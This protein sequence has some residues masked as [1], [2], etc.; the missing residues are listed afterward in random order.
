MFELAVNVTGFVSLFELL[1]LLAVIPGS[2]HVA[3]LHT[4]VLAADCASH[5]FAYA[6]YVHGGVNVL[7]YVLVVVD[8]ETLH[9]ASLYHPYVYVLHPGS[10]GVAVYVIAV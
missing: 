3:V 7:T 10:L 1:T 6:V 8:N 2:V 5:T 9:H 4:Q